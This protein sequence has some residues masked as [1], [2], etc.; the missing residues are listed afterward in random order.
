MILLEN[1]YKILE[2]KDSRFTIK[3][4]NKENNIFKAHFLNNEI[5]PAFIQIDII[6][7]LMRHKI[8]SI[9]KAKFLS[10]IR[11]DEIIIFN[12]SSK[13]NKKYKI[14]IKNEEEKK[15]SEIIYE[16]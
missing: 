12:V 4:A 6:A 13:D 11:P 9:K 16:I 3:L 8:K 2:T 14:I 1:L 5:L 15:M 7:Q 10:V